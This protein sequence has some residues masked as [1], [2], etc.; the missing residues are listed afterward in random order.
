MRVEYGPL[1]LADLALHFRLSSS[2]AAIRGPS[3]LPVFLSSP[4]MGELKPVLQGRSQAQEMQKVL[5]VPSIDK[6]LSSK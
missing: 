6:G 2:G 3:L 1:G 5:Q 4:A